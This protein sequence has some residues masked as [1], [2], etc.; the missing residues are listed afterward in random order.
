MKRLLARLQP[1]RLARSVDFRDAGD[2]RSGDI[3]R[4]TQMVCV[5]DLRRD[6]NSS[7]DSDVTNVLGSS[8]GRL[9]DRYSSKGETLD[10]MR[11][12]RGI[13]TRYDDFIISRPAKS[14]A[15]THPP[16]ATSR[17]VTS[18]RKGCPRRARERGSLC[19]PRC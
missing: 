18:G 14:R 6:I 10:L 13:A 1:A 7:A 2:P 19:V 9:S 8:R 15:T 4:H 5:N 12:G 3:R 17:N 16:R 11:G